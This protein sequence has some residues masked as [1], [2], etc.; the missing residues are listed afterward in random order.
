MVPT[1]FQVGA[2]RSQSVVRQQTTPLAAVEATELSAIPALL[3]AWRTIGDRPL[4][5]SYH[6]ISPIQSSTYTVSPTRFAEQMAL[7]DALGVHTLSSTEFR[8]YAAGKPVPPR[9]V[10]ITFDDGTR[11]VYRFADKVLAQHKFRAVSFIITGFVGT[12]APYYMTWAEID[13][14][15]RSG[16]WDFEAHTHI[17]HAKI[18]IDDKG[19][20]GSFVAN[21]AWLPELNRMETGAEQ[22][23]RLETDLDACI[24]LLNQHGYGRGH[25]FAFPFSDYGSPSNDA[26]VPDRLQLIVR[27]RFSNVFA[28]DIRPQEMAGPFQWN[29]L[30][31]NHEVTNA[32]LLA[33]LGLVIDLTS[34]S[35]TTVK[36]PAATRW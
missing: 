29:R 34:K 36:Q 31:I 13:K 19:T 15:S 28:D 14:L 32:S 17:G 30:S 22:R 33:N 5:I 8:D 9:S 7:L 25:L 20:V 2:E 21:L 35:S 16:R 11:G 26:S 3:D 4:V 12:R 18:P 23:T 24:N 10:M 6:D 1:G 27:A